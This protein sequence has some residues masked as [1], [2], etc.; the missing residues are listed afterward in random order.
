V[1]ERGGFKRDKDRMLVLTLMVRLSFP[2]SSYKELWTLV[3]IDMV[4]YRTVILLEDRF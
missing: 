2:F 3:C 1:E 4:D